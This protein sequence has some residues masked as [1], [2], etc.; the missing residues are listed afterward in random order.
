LKKLAKQIKRIGLIGNPEKTS[1]KAIITEAAR[2]VS[3]S[4]RSVQCDAITAQLSGLKCACHSSLAEL[5]A[6]VDLVL[7][8]GGDG[9]FLRVAREVAGLSTPILGINIGSLGFLTAVSSSG[10]SEALKR[11]WA[12]DFTLEPRALI[13]VKGNCAGKKI[14]ARAFN[15][16]VVSRGI[17]SRLITLDVCVD[18]EPLTRYRSDGFI[19][20]SPTGSTAYSLSA[21][22]AVVHPQAD[23]FELTP[24]CPHTLS[25]QSVIVSL[26]SKIEVKVVSVKPSTILSADGQKISELAAGD[27]VTIQRSRDS[28]RIMRLGGTSFFGTLRHK[29]HWMGAHV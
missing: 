24:I 23:V 21:G 29:L 22:G 5:T 25:N 27:S 7:V 26:N 28:V 1:A 20:S 4:G 19:V 11:V 17:D 8:F 18:G 13:E 12:G 16:F 2:L 15:D 14:Q 3:R 6:A 9:T 10:M